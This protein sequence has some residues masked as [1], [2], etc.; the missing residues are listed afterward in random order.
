MLV[1]WFATPI[2][3]VVQFSRNP[4][5]LMSRGISHAEQRAGDCQVRRIGQVWAQF[6]R[7]EY[8]RNTLR[9]IPS[10]GMSCLLHALLLLLLA[11]VFH[12]RRSGESLAFLIQPAIVDT[13]LGDVTSLVDSTRRRPVHN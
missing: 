8:D 6:G 7:G 3:V 12:L 4:F 13:Q 9:S 1:L 5:S 11:F 10:W 2:I